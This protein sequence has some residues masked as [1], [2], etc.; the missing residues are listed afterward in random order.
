MKLQEILRK[1]N[2]R[3]ETE[4]RKAKF[5]SKKK[6]KGRWVYTYKEAGE[7]KGSDKTIMSRMADKKD[8]E[9]LPA[10]HKKFLDKNK[11]KLE[12]HVTS[13][14]DT[15]SVSKKDI[16]GKSHTLYSSRTLGGAMNDAKNLINKVEKENIFL[17]SGGKSYPSSREIYGMDEKELKKLA[18]DVGAISNTAPSILAKIKNIK[19]RK[20]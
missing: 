4:L 11:I 17:E 14:N 3:N 13:P 18:S 9:L 7:K 12:F 19:N 6:V 10:Q 20:I 8:I 1:S 15:Y 16:K 2:I 5:L